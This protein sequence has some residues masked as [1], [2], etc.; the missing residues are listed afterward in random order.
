MKR[1]FTEN[2]ILM[3]ITAIVFL[4]NIYMLCA[5]SS[6]LILDL[7]WDKMDAEKIEQLDYNIYR[8]AGL[9]AGEGIEIL[10]E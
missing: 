7:F 10:E 8:I 3:V 9:P 1:F 2:R 6:S 5:F 4:A